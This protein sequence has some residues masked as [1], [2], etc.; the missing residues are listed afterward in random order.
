MDVIASPLVAEW[1]AERLPGRNDA[2]RFGQHVSIG[3][4]RNGKPVAGVVFS[5]FRQLDHGNDMQVTIVSA[6]PAW[7]R[8]EILRKLFEYPFV[9]A[10]CARLTAIVAEGNLPSLRFV[11][12]LGFRKEGIVRRGWNGKTNA[13]VFGLLKSECRYL[14]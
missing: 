6:G 5:G 3:V 4:V 7:A 12:R 13:I 10:G 8:P 2:E 9:E 11:K 1:V 14:G